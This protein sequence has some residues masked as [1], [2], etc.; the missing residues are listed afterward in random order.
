M[1]TISITDVAGTFGSV[2][3]EK[4][5]AEDAITP[6]FPDAPEDVRKALFDLQTALDRD[7]ST[8]REENFLGIVIKR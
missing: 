6:W 3:V 5:D 1:T 7:E 4:N 2:T 8:D